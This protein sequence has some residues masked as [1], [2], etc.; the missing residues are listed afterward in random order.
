M[1]HSTVISR[2]EQVAFLYIIVTNLYPPV[3]HSDD[4]SHHPN[5][6]FILIRVICKPHGLTD[7]QNLFTDVSVETNGFSQAQKDIQQPCL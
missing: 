6:I 5:Q 2:N 4:L 1:K 7:G 3:Q